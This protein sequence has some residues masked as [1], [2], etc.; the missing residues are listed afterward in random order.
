[1]VSLLATN[2]DRAPLKVEIEPVPIPRTNRPSGGIPLAPVS[3]R[4]SN[5]IVAVVLAEIST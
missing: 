1:M 5:E 2:F 3:A 4:A